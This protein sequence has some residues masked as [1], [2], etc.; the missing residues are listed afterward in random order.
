MAAHLN[1][2]LL[3]FLSEVL[4]SSSSSDSEDMLNAYV[5]KIRRPKIENFLGTINNYTDKE[6][7][8]LSILLMNI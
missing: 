6:V 3:P 7:R 1:G 5:N 2:L 4:E 8:L